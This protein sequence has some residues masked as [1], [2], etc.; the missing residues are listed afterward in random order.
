MIKK[1]LKEKYR[2][3]KYRK[4]LKGCFMNFFFSTKK[5]DNVVITFWFFR[6][7]GWRR[8]RYF[9]MATYFSKNAFNLL[10]IRPGIIL[11]YYR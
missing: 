8:K 11:D 2:E 9:N 4:E 1:K 10:K 6:I 7:F 5:Y 3:E